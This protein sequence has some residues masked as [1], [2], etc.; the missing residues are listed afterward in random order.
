LT[1][2]KLPPRPRPPLENLADRIETC[3]EPPG[4]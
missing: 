3:Y 2:E 1:A 4:S